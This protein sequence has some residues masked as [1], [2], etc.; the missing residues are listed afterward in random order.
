M[1][2][3]TETGLTTGGTLASWQAGIVG[4]IVGSVA[5]GAMMLTIIPK[6][7]LEVAIPN[8]VGVKA[9]PKD[10][11]LAVGWVVHLVIGSGMGLAYA[12]AMQTEAIGGFV[13]DNVRTLAAGLGYGVVT[14]VAG[15]VIL[16]P[17]LLGGVMGFGG[18]PSLP[19]IK[20][21][22]LVGHLVFGVLLAFVYQLLASG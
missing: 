11:A 3:Q 13:T 10:P 22:G 5:F 16:M 12:G 4:G 6:P 19:N 14:W 2:T 18:A 20:P 9:T 7:V 21:L 1:S 17:V 8:L 15:G